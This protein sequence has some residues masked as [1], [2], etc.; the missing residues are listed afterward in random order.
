VSNS[1]RRPLLLLLFFFFCLALLPG[2]Q[3]KPTTSMKGS[4]TAALLLLSLIVR[5]G[6]SAESFPAS[7]RTMNR[8]L[9][10]KIFLSNGASLAV[11]IALPFDDAQFKLD[12]QCSATAAIEGTT[13]IGE[14]TSDV[15]Y[16][17]VLDNSG[18]I[19]PVL[20]EAIRAF[21]VTLTG[22]I[23][24]EGSAKNA[25]VVFFG[26]DASIA[27][28]LTDNQKAITTAISTPTNFGITECQAGLERAEE[29]LTTSA[30]E[31]G[32]VVLIFAGDGECDSLPTDA[33]DALA[34][35]GVII[36]TLAIG[37]GVDC[38][39]DLAGITR[40]GGQ[41][42]DID[43]PVDF[44]ITNVIGTTLKGAEIRQDSDTYASLTTSPNVDT[45]GPTT[46]TFDTSVVISGVTSSTVC[47]RATGDDIL[48]EEGDRTVEQCITIEGID[49]TPPDI[50]CPADQAFNT[51]QGVCTA[52][53]TLKAPSVTDNCDSLSVT[54]IK[55]TFIQ[56]PT[57]VDYSVTDKS[58]NKSTCKF[59][60]SVADNEPPA[61][62]CPADQAFNTDPGV[63]TATKTLDAPSV[64]DNCDSLSVAAIKDTFI[65]GTTTVDYSVT[66]DSLNMSTCGFEVSVVDNEP[67]SASC[68]PAS[69]PAGNEPQADNQDG[70]F[71][72]D[73]GD[74]CAVSAI[75]VVDS[76]SG[77]RFGPY[78][79]LTTFKYVEAP[80][81]PNKEK[82]GP[83]D[84]DYKLT[85]NGDAYV[86]VIDTNGNESTSECLVPPKP[87]RH[88]RRE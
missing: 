67:P 77:H 54:A 82:L 10:E 69:N 61:I 57:Q 41:C 78:D 53:K 65:Q 49:G 62:T 26:S 34:N 88:L 50:T 80:G 18:S 85:G 11:D 71:V 35:R 59:E 74:N 22:T 44:D 86:L 79:P 36:E 75:Y 72:L 33:A 30:I 84:V 58:G 4:F 20:R 43:D 6:A 60:V 15:T 31:G 29:I 55:D 81:A 42:N 28:G 13:S 73:G 46:K 63:C 40:N 83:G 48:T 9:G 87:A 2:K 8:K 64:T 37:S 52:T 45:Q 39:G 17:F 68:E 56:G 70:F 23:F 19:S 12:G 16:I 32:T 51:D 27:Q 3:K 47:V 1:T 5:V 21:F 66:D 76:V 14:G 25:G 7:P 24:D 38:S